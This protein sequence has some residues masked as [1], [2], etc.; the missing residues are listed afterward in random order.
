MGHIQGTNRHEVI[1][2][3]ER[4]DDYLLEDNPVRFIDTFVDELDLEMLGFQRVKAAATG[5]PA[6]HPGDLL[7]LYLDG[8][9]YRLRSS[10]R[11]EQATHRHIA[12]LWLLKTLR[13]A[14]QTLAKLRRHPLHSRRQVCRACTLLCPQLDRFSGEL[15]AIDGSK[16]KAVHAKERTFTHSKLQ[17]LLPLVHAQI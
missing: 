16:F 17:R 12:L 2:F 5:R 1:L 11:L 9:L 4:L 7:K 13:P 8:Y 3:P 6:Y 14:Q 10:R 15:V